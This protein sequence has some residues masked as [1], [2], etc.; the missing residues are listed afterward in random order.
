MKIINKYLNLR[1]NKTTYDTDDDIKNDN[2]YFNENAMKDVD[3]E[4][5]NIDDGETCYLPKYKSF[6]D[7]V[8]SEINPISHQSIPLPKHWLNKHELSNISDINKEYYDINY[9]NLSIHDIIPMNDSNITNCENCQKELIQSEPKD[10]LLYDV[11][12]SKQIKYSDK[13]CS[14]CMKTFRFDGKFNK[15]FH[16]SSN[17]LFTHRLL[18]QRA[19]DVYISGTT[20]YD[21]TRKLRSL[22]DNSVSGNICNENQFCDYRTYTKAFIGFVYLLEILTPKELICRSCNISNNIQ[23]NANNDNDNNAENDVNPKYKFGELPHVCFDGVSIILPMRNCKT[24]ISIKEP[25]S[26][27]SIVDNTKIKDTGRYINPPQL[28]VLSQRLIYT[29]F[30]KYLRQKDMDKL[31]DQQIQH[32]YEQLTQKGYQH[33]VAFVKYTTNDDL[34]LPKHEIS[35]I[36]HFLHA[37]TA[38][39]QLLQVMHPKIINHEH[40]DENVAQWPIIND[41]NDDNDT[42]YE[43]YSKF[44]NIPNNQINIAKFAPII[45]GLVYGTCIGKTPI[46]FDL[47]NHMKLR[48]DDIVKIY[49]K[50]TNHA[51]V[52][53]NHQQKQIIDNWL[54]SGQCYAASFKRIPP[55]WTKQYKNTNDDICNKTFID[56]KKRS[57]L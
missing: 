30:G 21:A 27:S 45:H 46:T 13:Y 34:L 14:Q 20:W 26:N 12:V 15:I 25:F 10:G 24:V 35:L 44:F 17:I 3:N 4:N 8:K 18:L 40:N 5:D 31:N 55:I 50:H 57:G 49:D 43:I 42:N 54:Y 38:A 41:D 11:D 9:T 2:F 6:E 29:L 51:Y 22:Y 33:L 7:Y 53:P 32:V 47:L 48:F 19:N 52:E 28:R 1:N 23:M 37:V 16:Y 39:E 56:F 36:K